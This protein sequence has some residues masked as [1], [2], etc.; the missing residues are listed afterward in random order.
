MLDRQIHTLSL[1]PAA[2][3]GL[4]G[5]QALSLTSKVVSISGVKRYS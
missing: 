3:I 2:S 4:S 5:L 1:A